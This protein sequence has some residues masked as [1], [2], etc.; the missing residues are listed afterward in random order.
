M[1]IFTDFQRSSSMVSIGSQPFSGCSFPARSWWTRAWPLWWES[2]QVHVTTTVIIHTW[3]ALCSL[4][5]RWLGW[6]AL[7]PGWYLN[8]VYSPYKEYCHL[9]S[10]LSPTKHTLT[11]KGGRSFPMV[12]ITMPHVIHGS[13][14]DNS[15]GSSIPV[16]TACR[17]SQ[18]GRCGTW[19]FCRSCFLPLN[20]Q[21]GRA[22]QSD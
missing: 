22:T 16:R 5:F 12:I 8:I 1:D 15:W 3:C 18:A 21:K 4:L 7:K 14:R 13:Y 20:L 10:I 17:A 9:Q 6:I 19:S 2:E 11:Y